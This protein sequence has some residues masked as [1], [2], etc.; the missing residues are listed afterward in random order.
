MN[1]PLKQIGHFEISQC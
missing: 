1:A